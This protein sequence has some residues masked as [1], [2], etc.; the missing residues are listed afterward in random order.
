MEAASLDLSVALFRKASVKT[1]E[2]H[3]NPNPNISIDSTIIAIS[4]FPSALEQQQQQ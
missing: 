3:K 1:F 4:F 2:R